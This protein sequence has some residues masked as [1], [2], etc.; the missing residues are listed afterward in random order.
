VSVCECDVNVD[1]IDFAM[2]F[3]TWYVCECVRVCVQ[4][5]VNVCMCMCVCTC[6]CVCVCVCV[7]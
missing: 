5:C 2:I 3:D 1:A 7:V 4:V 6:M